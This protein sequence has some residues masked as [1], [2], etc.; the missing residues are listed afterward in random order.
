MGG[1]GAE[2]EDTKVGVRG[3]KDVK[4][5]VGRSATLTRKGPDEPCSIVE[6]YMLEGSE[7]EDIVLVGVG[8]LEE[9]ET[10][11]GGKLQK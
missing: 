10:Q 5:R 3:I 11:Q 9:A 4:A 2:G 6:V 1:E 8:S 7:E